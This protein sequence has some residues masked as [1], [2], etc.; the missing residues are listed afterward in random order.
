MDDG[1]GLPWGRRRGKHRFGRRSA[2]ARRHLPAAA[3]AAVLAGERAI[4]EAQKPAGHAAAARRCSTQ[5]YD[6]SDR[7]MPGVMMSGGR[8][9][10]QDGVRV[11]LPAGATWDG[12]AAMT[13]DEIRERG[14]AARAASCR[15]RTSS[16]RPAARSFPSSRST[17]SA[18]QEAARPAALRCRLRSARPPH[19]GVPAAD[20]PDHASR[21]RRRL[22]RPAADDQEL[23]RAD[24]RH[25]HAGADGRPAAAADAVPAGGVQPDRGP[26]GRGAEPGRRP[27]STATRTSTPTPPST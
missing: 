11:K 20:L 3:D 17:R 22:A 23:L 27:A 19:A 10:V 13:P 24:E 16:R 5:R 14:P 15:C 6:L 21:A 1:H 9:P 7:P 2:A 4:D 8:K 12:L 18:S 26:Q 25:P